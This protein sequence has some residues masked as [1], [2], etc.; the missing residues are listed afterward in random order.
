MSSSRAAEPRVVTRLALLSALVLFGASA[1]GSFGAQGTPTPALVP[2]KPAAPS[3]QLDQ[4]T[5]TPA[6][7]AENAAAQ[8]NA[9]GAARR[10]QAGQQVAPGQGQQGAAGQGQRGAGQAGG[11]RPAGGGQT[12][13]GPAGGR[14]GPAAA[15]TTQ[16]VYTDAQAA[17]PGLL[18]RAPLPLSGEFAVTAN[19]DDHSLSV[20]PI[21][22]A[23]AIET[24]PL[25]VAP[26]AVATAPDSDTAVT[27]PGAPEARA[28]A[29][30][31]LNTSSHA[32]SID[33]SAH[34]VQVVSPGVEDSGVVVVIGDDDTLR[35]LDA[36]THT[37]GAPITLDHGPHALGFGSGGAPTAG[38]L[39]VANAAAGTVAI[40]DDR[41]TANQH[42][43]NVGGHPIGV[44]QTIDSRLWIA[45]AD[46]G[47]VVQ[48]DQE[49]GG[50]LESIPVGPNLTSLAV[51]RDGHY[52]VLSSSDPEHALYAVDL[53]K[54]SLGRE[55]EVVK[56]LAVSGGVLALATGAE[57]TRAY[58]TTGDGML[59]YWDL[60][61]NAVTQTIPVGKNPV[62][63]AIGMVVPSGTIAQARGT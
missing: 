33:A 20:V 35:P 5:A 61:A 45:D 15:S 22:M 47:A 18:L 19:L 39:Y 41:A 30:A 42:L 8:P 17:S 58:A 9:A 34:L 24:V 37:L 57:P 25:D 54:S 59:I 29:L 12:G 62:G 52:L 51:T 32:P 63:L 43:L 2:V 14:P 28:L 44:A 13:A 1:C 53:L 38:R 4:P 46:V 6:A 27:V 26:Y 10:G 50:R 21:G 55:S 48:V 36:A 3:E 56:P 31:S 23:R 40:L 49:S 7:G 60:E 16:A 11:G